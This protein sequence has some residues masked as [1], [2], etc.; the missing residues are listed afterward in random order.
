MYTTKKLFAIS[1]AF[2]LL[3]A[4]CAGLKTKAE[5]CS[6]VGYKIVEQEKLVISN[7]S[8]EVLVIARHDLYPE[9]DAPFESYAVGIIFKNHRM[10]FGAL[11]DNELDGTLDEAYVAMGEMDLK[12]DDDKMPFRPLAPARRIQA[13]EDAHRD[14]KTLQKIF[15]TC[16]VLTIHEVR[17]HIKD[18][19][20]GSEL[21]V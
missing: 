3:L 16:D 13:N 15:S 2:L 12:A 18:F 9:K 1:A 4:A 20:N 14:F 5:K 10:F 19:I 7:V 11:I 21:A 8:P 17:Q 6:T